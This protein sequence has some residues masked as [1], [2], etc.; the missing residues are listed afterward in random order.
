MPTGPVSDEI[1]LLNDIRD[2]LDS[3][4]RVLSVQVA[5]DKSLTERAR[6]LKL[7]GLDNRTIASVLNTTPA[8]IRTVTANLRLHR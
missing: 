4:L 6:I 8:T 5:S 7:V 3:I 1:A 2:K